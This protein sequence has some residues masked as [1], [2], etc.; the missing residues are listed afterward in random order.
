MVGARDIE[1]QPLNATDQSR[2]AIDRLST[3]AQAPIG[4]T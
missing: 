2:A 4:V 3:P 1:T